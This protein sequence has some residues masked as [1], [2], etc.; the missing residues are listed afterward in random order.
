MQLFDTS[1][2]D[3]GEV[4]MVR[5]LLELRR[6]HHGDGVVAL[7]CGANIGVHTVEWAT[8]MTGWGTVV[9]FEPQERIFYALAGNIAINNCFNA[10]A[11]HAAVGRES[12]VIQMPLL[13]YT[14]PASYGSFELQKLER[15]Q[16][17]G[18]EIDYENGQKMEVNLISIDDLDC[19]R[20]DFIKLDIEGMELDALEGAVRTL[21]TLKPILLVEH[22][23]SK[24]GTL[25]PFLE[26]LG[27][28]CF[29]TDLNIVAAHQDDPCL[30][31]INQG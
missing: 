5:Q 2:F 30:A 20:C 22:I 27:Y 17:I 9:A 1:L 7:D 13:D 21:T 4:D 14:K 11:L 25:Q 10:R 29:M 6:L 3:A 31:S 18:Q 23:K 16:F 28:R 12:A 26:A 15:S 19:E 8:L 24:P